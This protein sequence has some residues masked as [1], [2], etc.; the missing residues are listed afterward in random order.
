MIF[1]FV[2]KHN[3]AA[4]GGRSV[5]CSVQLPAR[6][7]QRLPAQ[8]ARLGSQFGGG[9][10]AHLA[11]GLFQRP[12]LKGPGY[13]EMQAGRFDSKLFPPLFGCPSP[14]TMTQ[15]PRGWQDAPSTLLLPPSWIMG[16]LGREG[17]SALC[18]RR[19]LCATRAPYVWLG[20]SAQE[21]ALEGW[22]GWSPSGRR[23]GYL[24]WKTTQ[25]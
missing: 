12:Q 2:S 1:P 21:P 9:F 19:N 4:L 14:K 25:G 22:M 16:L 18:C 17:A 11:P 3:L 23:C 8:R 24:G 6:Q 20:P 13:K 15:F 5:P 10:I 7:R